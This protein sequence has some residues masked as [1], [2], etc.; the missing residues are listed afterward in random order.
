MSLL[1][2][3]LARDA[4]RQWAQFGAVALTLALAVTVFGAAYDAY[5]NLTS[6]YAEVYDRFAFADV[7]VTGGDTEALASELRDMDGVAAV[8]LR[9]QGEVPFRVNAGSEQRTLL[10][11]IVAQPPDPTVNQLLVEEGRGPDDGSGVSRTAP[12]PPTR[13]SVDSRKAGRAACFI[14]LEPRRA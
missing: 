11:R 5:R 2:R 9:D 3:K 8:E 10:G 4:R 14:P 7:T 6:S 12:D 13:S 1:A